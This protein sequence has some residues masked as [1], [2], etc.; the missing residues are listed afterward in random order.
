MEK[1]DIYRTICGIIRIHFL[2]DF[3]GFFLSMPTP[4]SV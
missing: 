3:S 2:G 1:K 4:G